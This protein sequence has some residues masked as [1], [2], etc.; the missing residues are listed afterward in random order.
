MKWLL[1]GI[2]VLAAL[3]ALVLAIGYATP[4]THRA[5]VRAVYRAAPDVVYREIFDVARGAEWRTALERVEVLSDPAQPA[6][7][8]EVADWGELTFV[9]EAAEPPRRI[10]SRIV[11]EGQGFGGTWTWQLTPAGS[12]TELVIVENGVVDNPLYRFM[13]KY[14]MG[15]YEGVETYA[16]DLGRRLGEEVEPVRVE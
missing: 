16:R 6:R 12:G 14:V 1:I 15:Y 8:R 4:R 13:S 5:A 7:W 11:D 2:G 9:H 3:G 10:V